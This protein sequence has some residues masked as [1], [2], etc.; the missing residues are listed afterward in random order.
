MSAAEEKTKKRKRDSNNSSRP[1]KKVVTESDSQIKVGLLEKDH[2]APVIASSPGIEISSSITF[3]SYSKSRKSVGQQ[4]SPISRQELLL[5]SSR[6]PKLDYLAKEEEDGGPESLRRHYVGVFD[7]KTGQLDV[8]EARKMVIRGMVRARHHD[9]QN[10]IVSNNMKEQRNLLG[11]TFGTKKARK[12]IAS[13]TENAISPDK[14]LRTG[15][16]ETKVDSKSAVILASV[17]EATKT[18]TSRDDLAKTADDAKPRPKANELA[19][20][21]KDVYTVESLIGTNI[22]NMVPVKEWQDRLLANEEVFIRS[23]FVANRIQS[24]AR[25]VEKLKILRYTLMLIELYQS[26]KQS[27]GGRKLCR[28]EELKELMGD[29]PEAVLGGAKRKFSEGGIINKYHCDLLITHLCAM[30][31]LIDNFETDTSDLKEDLQLELSKMTKYYAEIG[32]KSSALGKS[33]TA[34]IGKV[35]AAQRRLA[36]LKLPLVFP[37]FSFG[38][39]RK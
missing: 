30:S 11:Q 16:T 37:K 22:L 9:D 20:N 39:N 5:H 29:M 6:H 35:A 1:T 23:K 4:R 10:E 19:T 27:R 38:V 25:D 34:R 18:M 13:I 12:A 7:P 3:K 14:S 36:K 28:R 33:E 31:L 17:A 15:G 24:L 21:V 2:F 8:I 32:A 26:S